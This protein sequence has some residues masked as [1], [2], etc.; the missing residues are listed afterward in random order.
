M[1]DTDRLLDIQS[2]AGQLLRVNAERR[3]LRNAKRNIDDRL[4]VLKD[5][6]ARL[7]AAINILLPVDINA[8]PVPVKQPTLKEE[9]QNA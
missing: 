6:M 8:M 9:S 3:Q 5:D 4:A 1:T 2:L 7:E